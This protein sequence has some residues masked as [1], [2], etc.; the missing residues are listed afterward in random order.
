[1]DLDKGIKDDEISTQE[2][3]ILDRKVR[4]FLR[5]SWSRNL[6]QRDKQSPGGKVLQEEEPV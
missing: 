6:L 3:S 2:D 1:M 4:G 5:S